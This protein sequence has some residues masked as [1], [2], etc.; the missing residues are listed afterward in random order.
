MATHPNT[1]A[2]IESAILLS[3]IVELPLSPVNNQK[4]I[5][6]R[7]IGNRFHLHSFGKSITKLVPETRE[8]ARKN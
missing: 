5:G 2:D 4:L 8:E 3:L 6:S 7:K 1:N